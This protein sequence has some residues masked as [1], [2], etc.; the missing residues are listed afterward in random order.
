MKEW[1]NATV[2][3]VSYNKILQQKIINTLLWY[4]LRFSFNVKF[5]WKFSIFQLNRDKSYPGTE[6]FMMLLIPY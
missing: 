6:W 4:H 3:T 5:K 1:M 2:I